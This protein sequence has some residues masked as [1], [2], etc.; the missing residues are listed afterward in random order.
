MTNSFTQDL[1]LSEH[2]HDFN[3]LNY[4]IISANRSTES[5]A[6]SRRLAG[7][8]VSGGPGGLQS[9]LSCHLPSSGFFRRTIRN[10][11]NIV[12][13]APPPYLPGQSLTA[14]QE[15][16]GVNPTCKIQALG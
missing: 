1:V 14:R 7:K 3:S 13:N 6:R 9:S 16:I 12:N 15:K 8:L 10:F 5:S 4:V 2:L 11:V